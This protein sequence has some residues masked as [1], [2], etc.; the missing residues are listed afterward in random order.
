[1]SMQITPSGDS[2]ENR[3]RGHLE[4]G[5]GFLWSQMGPEPRAELC[6]LVFLPPGWKVENC[7][8]SQKYPPLIS[9]G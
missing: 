7:G 6:W 3:R 4:G 9:P 2:W 8:L 1:M 5:L